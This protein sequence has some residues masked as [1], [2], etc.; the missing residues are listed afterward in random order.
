MQRQI[1]SLAIPNIISNIS[2]P[3]VSTVDT[4]LMGHLNSSNLAA[5]GIVSMIFLF[6][7]GA[8]NFLRMGTT[9]LTAQAF[10]R[11]DDAQSAQ[12]LY[13]ALV[14]AL[15]LGLTLLILQDALQQ[16]SFYLMNVA[17][18]YHDEAERYFE[19]RIW[20]APAVFGLYALGGWYF[21]MQ[22][23]VYPL[24]ITLA[25]NVL[26]MLLSYYF[27]VE[28]GLGIEGAAYGTLI[29][30]YGG[31]LLGLAL[32]Y[33]YRDRLIPLRLNTLLQPDAL[34]AFL[35]VNR[36][37]FIRTTVLTFIFAFFYA[38][39]AKAGEQTLG[40]MILLL[41]FI[42]WFSY[43]LD[44]FANA[45]ESISGKFYG[46][47][48]RARFFQSVKS[49]FG[50]GAGMTVLYML[51]YGFYGEDIVRL[52]TDQAAVIERALPF[53]P[54]VSMMPLLGFAAFIW[55]GV[56]VGMTATLALRNAILVSAALFLAL[57]YL[58]RGIDFT[59]ALWINFLLFFFF[60]G[61]IQTWMFWRQGMSLR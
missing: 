42:V 59:Y 21:G 32:L 1:L 36:Q 17:D 53:L 27:V 7:Y 9:G 58:T 22:N 12:T 40:A 14:V 51:I 31:L 10:G 15:L 49:L 2:V 29:G 55:D 28:M 45:A 46:A 33:R 47:R 50:W 30:Q 18:S 11:K 23:A 60:R 26:N 5:L 54:Y 16:F 37:I 41:Q 13:R 3:L 39:A 43:S 34:G 44:G 24:L 6:L 25:V 4:M 19:L 8:M 35:H 61:A 52:Y 38:Q 56:F 57:F 48:D 20:T